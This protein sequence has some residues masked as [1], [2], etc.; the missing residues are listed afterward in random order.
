MLRELKHVFHFWQN[1]ARYVGVSDDSNMCV[2]DGQEHR[3]VVQ[4]DPE[5]LAVNILPEAGQST[6]QL[7]FS[8]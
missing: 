7:P 4:P 5:S 6:T 1:V 3:T 8:I 2:L